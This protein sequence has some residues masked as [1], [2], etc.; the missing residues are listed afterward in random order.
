MALALLLTDRLASDD[1]DDTT[2]LNWRG[3][4][5]STLP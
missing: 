2:F 3:H 5:I 4:D 1:D